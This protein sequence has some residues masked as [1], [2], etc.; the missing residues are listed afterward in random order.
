MGLATLVVFVVLTTISVGIGL[1]LTNLVR[2]GEGLDPGV[3]A[4]LMS[5]YGGEAQ[6]AAGVVVEGIVDG[7]A[8]PIVRR[9]RS[10]RR[11]RRHARRGSSFP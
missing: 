10:N 4:E 6:D 11:P 1:T 8:G 5:A 7:S 9:N 3:R 2:P